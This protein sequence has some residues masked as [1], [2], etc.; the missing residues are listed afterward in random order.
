MFRGKAKGQ[1]LKNTIVHTV[2]GFSIVILILTGMPPVAVKLDRPPILHE[3]QY[4]LKIAQR[5]PESTN[6]HR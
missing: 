6:H 1:F 3:L 5:V 2:K 4:P